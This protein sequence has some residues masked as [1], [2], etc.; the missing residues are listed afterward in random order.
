M[1]RDASLP[2]PLRL[3]GLPVIHPKTDPVTE[4][5]R[6][7]VW[8][9]RLA[10][11]QFCGA[12]LFLLVTAV[13]LQLA[14]REVL[15]DWFWVVFAYVYVILWMP[16]LLEAM[17]ILWLVRRH[18]SASFSLQWLLLQ[19]FLPPLR[20]MP[21]SHV[22]PGK[23]VWLPRVGWI[24]VDAA[25]R[26]RLE[27]RFNLP[28]LFFAMLIIPV[29]WVDFAFRKETLAGSWLGLS[30]EWATAIIW[31]AFTI[32]FIVMVSVAKK[33][34]G[35]CKKHWMDL[36]IILLPLVA[37]LRGLRL[38]QALRMTNTV[39]YL[40]LK[41][42]ASRLFRALVLLEWIQR[43]LYRTPEKDLALLYRQRASM[44]QELEQLEQEIHALEV[45]INPVI[46][47]K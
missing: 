35:Y 29:I 28:M 36:V 32:E 16:F 3:C 22:R 2:L 19:T 26:H 6:L 23:T 14:Q 47:R 24:A 18:R 45:K 34:F 27:K 37:F 44:T 8:E 25:L 40:K 33:S 30:L 7:R 31:L 17:L 38:F 42:G 5:H 21:R 15:A 46:P 9:K 43:L 10:V 13:F 41:G 39:R 1:G 11:P 4:D 12:L 20:L